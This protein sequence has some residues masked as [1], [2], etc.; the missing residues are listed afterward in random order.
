MVA[1]LLLA[2]SMA[3]GESDPAPTGAA[4]PARSSGADSESLAVP[5][6]DDWL[7]R[8][9]WC[10]CPNCRKARKTLA[11]CADRCREPQVR[12]IEIVRGGSRGA[13][14]AAPVPATPAVAEDGAGT[15]GGGPVEPPEGF[16]ATLREAL[17]LYV[18]AAARQNQPPDAAA[19]LEAR[20]DAL[21]AAL[22][23]LNGGYAGTGCAGATIVDD[24][25]GAISVRL[26]PDA[27]LLGLPRKGVARARATGVADPA[28]HRLFLYSVWDTTRARAVDAWIRDRMA[29][30]DF[31]GRAILA[32]PPPEGAGWIPFLAVP[33]LL[34][35]AGGA[36]VMLWRRWRRATPETGPGVQVD[37]PAAAPAEAERIERELRTLD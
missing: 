32:A 9:L 33:L 13:S 5:T 18:G 29:A 30:P 8:E 17:A 7:L 12:F 20:A 24:R 31:L 37:E 34:A 35:L 27:D 36:L 19:A 23:T 26:A 14:S 4:S 2:A 10:A 21:A 16:P 3:G 22:V 15:A 1:A 28:S 11:A 6:T 25:A